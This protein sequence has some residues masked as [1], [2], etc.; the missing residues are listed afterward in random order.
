MSAMNRREAMQTMAGVLASFV[1]PAP[2]PRLDLKK[3]CARLPG[4][5]Y[6]F[7]LPYTLRDFTYAT[8][9]HLA[10]RVRPASADRFEREGKIPP[11]D[12]LSW[13]H[14]ALR[15]WRNL[16]KL[17]ALE[18]D[19]SECPACEGC[20]RTRGGVPAFGSECPNCH[21]DAVGHFPSIVRLD[22]RYFDAHLYA[23][24][25]DRGGEYLHD[26]LYADP[27]RSLLK[28]RLDGGLGMLA[29]MD[30]ACVERWLVVR[31]T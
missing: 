18:A 15:G 17:E 20:G 11:F 5:K 16:P 28:F 3:F 7:T 22:G 12:S 21:G 1:L 19:D 14:D 6:D 10:L 9:G 8:D 2:R 23:K 13:N 4:P 27:N 25:R 24:V 30:A 26:N 29:G 31:K